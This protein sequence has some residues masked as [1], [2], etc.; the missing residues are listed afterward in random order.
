MQWLIQEMSTLPIQTVTKVQNETLIT[1]FNSSN[2]YDLWAAFDLQVEECQNTREVVDATIQ[3]K[4][5][6]EENI[7]QRRADP[8]N[9]WKDHE[10]HYTLLSVLALKYLSMR[11]TSVPSEWVFLKAG[12]LASS[13]RSR[14][15]PQNIDMLL[16]TNKNLKE[17]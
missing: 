10:K 5:C 3:G 13:E 9:W 11:G 12:E 6:L 1:N 7:Y 8:L 2:K 4:H 17:L 16:F 15:K 14:I